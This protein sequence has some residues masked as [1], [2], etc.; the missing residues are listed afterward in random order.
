MD[1]KK[2]NFE[3]G[4]VVRLK[5]GGPLM[6]IKGIGKYGTA[7]TH[8]TAL[9]VWFEGTSAKERVFEIHTLEPDLEKIS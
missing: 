3:P 5:S 7:A 8:D 4:A 2:Y 6:T 9:C 1:S